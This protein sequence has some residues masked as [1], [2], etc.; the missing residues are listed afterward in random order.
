[1]M[2]IETRE[3]SVNGRTYYIKE[4]ELKKTWKNLK[5]NLIENFDR[6]KAF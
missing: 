2:K 5:E 3:T 1:M 6:Q 4:D